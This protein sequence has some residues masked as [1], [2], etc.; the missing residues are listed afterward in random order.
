MIRQRLGDR[1]KAQL[2]VIYGRRHIGK[3]TLIRKA[4]SDEKRVLYF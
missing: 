4:V 2:I 1:L 3:S